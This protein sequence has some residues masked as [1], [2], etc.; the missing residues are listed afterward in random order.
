MKKLLI[1]GF[2]T[3][4]LFFCVWLGLSQIDLRGFFKV[5]EKA[6]NTEEKLGEYFLEVY[7]QTEEENT[8][9][10]VIHA[11]DSIV[12]YICEAND[13]DRSEI[14][15]HVFNTSE[16]N[17]F[18]LPDGHLLVYSGLILNAGNPEALAG[19]ISHEIAHIELNHVMKKLIKE[20]GLSILISMATGNNTTDAI[21]E[22]AQMLS[23]TAFD[24]SFETDADIRAVDYMIK[25]DVDPE[26]FANF[27]YTLD[28]GGSD[29]LENLSWLSTHPASKERA[30]YIVDYIKDESKDYKSVLSLDT[31]NK[32][33]E[34][35]AY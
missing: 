25:A 10:T 2:I 20:I 14:K 24:R 21:G 5:Q 33:Q 13:I 16:I 26:P 28:D 34:D 32:L 35:L 7:K 4:L 23:S 15:L 3:I 18:A 22:T 30:K 8:N 11:V 29:I 6:D 1:Q 19:V 12:N 31:W 17:A 27:L 9:S